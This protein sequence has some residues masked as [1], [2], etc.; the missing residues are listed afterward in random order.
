M[1]GDERAPRHHPVDVA[2]A[3][4]VDE[5]GPLAA[6]DEDRVAPDRLH[7]PNRRVHAAGDQLLSPRI[8]VAGYACS[9]SH[10]LCSSVKY[11]SRIFLNS[12]EE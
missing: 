4:D 3:V 2:V 7:R 5:L 10:R 9:A 6:L 1:A 12:V 11:R 8:Q